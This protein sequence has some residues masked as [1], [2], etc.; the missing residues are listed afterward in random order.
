[1]ALHPQAQAVLDA[2]QASGAVAAPDSSPEEARRIY[3]S[4]PDFSGE[5]APVAAVEDRV[6]PGPGGELTVRIYSPDPPSP[7]P[8]LIYFHGGGWVMGSIDAVDAPLRAVANG[9]G[10]VVFS[11]DYRLAPEDPFPAAL[12]DAR[13]V[14]GWVAEQAGPLGV[15]AGRIAVGG[16]SA[17]GNL[18]AATTLAERD[19]GPHIAG[20]VLIYPVLDHDFERPSYVANAEGFGMTTDNMKWYWDH[21]LP[22]PER[23]SDPLASPLRATDLTDLPPALVITAEHDVLRDEA[24][25]YAARLRAAGVAVTFSRYDGMMHGFFRTA[26]AVDGG[27]ALIDEIAA[28]LRTMPAPE[29]PKRA[30]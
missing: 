30:G 28:W 4:A 8:A 20:Q 10:C 19:R 9:S 5:R 16:D 25:E 24:E 13:A 12:E 18:T 14:L 22:D 6:L 7:A 15:D 2:Q 26:G 29:E 21:Y 3:N 1:V 17:G 27:R 11:V 23:R